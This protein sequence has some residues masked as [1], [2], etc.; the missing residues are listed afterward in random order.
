[1]SK[2]VDNRAGQIFF[3]EVCG[4]RGL[5]VTEVVWMLT[6]RR[7]SAYCPGA[8]AEK[9][10]ALAEA[11]GVEVPRILSIEEVDRL[12]VFGWV[13]AVVM[14]L[15]HPEN[16][17]ENKAVMRTD[18]AA[19]VIAGAVKGIDPFEAEDGLRKAAALGLIKLPPWA[20]AGENG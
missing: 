18:I 8:C 11:M 9:I 15:N 12:D 19:F 10:R 7:T 1:M 17:L 16:G 13:V 2:S 3:C 14:N 6:G 4:K 5:T 20:A